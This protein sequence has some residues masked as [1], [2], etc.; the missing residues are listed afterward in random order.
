MRR[1]LCRRRTCTRWGLREQSAEP[2]RCTER[3]FHNA[4]PRGPLERRSFDDQRTGGG[5]AERPSCLPWKVGPYLALRL[6]PVPYEEPVEIALTLVKKPSNARLAHRTHTW[7]SRRP[8][9]G[10]ETSGDG[11]ARPGRACASN[12]SARIRRGP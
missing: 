11:I 4:V 9:V 1:S 5:G 6:F 10:W 3:A 2:L 12:W 8:R 7:S